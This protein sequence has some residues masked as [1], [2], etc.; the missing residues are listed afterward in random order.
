ME[1]CSEPGNPAENDSTVG[2]SSGGKVSYDPKC[3]D[4]VKFDGKDFG[5]KYRKIVLTRVAG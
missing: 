1:V 5:C 2:V 3:G 4:Y